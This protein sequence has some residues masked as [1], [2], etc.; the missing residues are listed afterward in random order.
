MAVFTENIFE[1]EGKSAMWVKCA[2]GGY[3]GRVA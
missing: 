1:S 2:N 3:C